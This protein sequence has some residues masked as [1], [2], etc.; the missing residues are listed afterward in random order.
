M[1]ETATDDA[2]LLDSPS[3]VAPK[4]IAPGAVAESQRPQERFTKSKPLVAFTTPPLAAAVAKGNR[5]DVEDIVE[6]TEVPPAS[7][8]AAS[9]LPR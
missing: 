2:F 5:E 8:S 7:A 6:L 9:S 1:A 3:L 4:G